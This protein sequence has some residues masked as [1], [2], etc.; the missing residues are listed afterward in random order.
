[1]VSPKVP[2][3]EEG[4]SLKSA[5]ELQEAGI[6]FKKIGG[7]NLF[8]IRFVY[9]TMEIPTLEVEDDTELFFRNVIAYEQYLPNTSRDYFTAYQMVI[10]YLVNTSK[11]VKILTHHGIIINYLGDN[12]AVA[13]M[14]NK[15]GNNVMASYVGY[16]EV[17]KNVNKHC[18]GI[19]NFWLAILRRD[20]FNNPWSFISFVAAVVLLL[21]TVLQTIFTIHPV[22][23]FN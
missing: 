12:E 23:K 16:E 13:T 18:R 20:Y 19:W 8:N 7:R 1:M 6:K 3:K 4:N 2:I 10:D 15:L 5:T 14:F 11:D 17:Y 21:F 22:G 9:G